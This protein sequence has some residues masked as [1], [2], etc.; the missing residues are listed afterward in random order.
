[1]PTVEYFNH[2]MFFSER[3]QTRLN[4][5]GNITKKAKEVFQCG[6]CHALALALHEEAGLP[7][8]GLYNDSDTDTPSHVVVQVKGNVLL[9]IT[10][11]GPE[12]TPLWRRCEPRPLTKQ[13][14]EQFAELDYLEPNKDV[15][16]PFAKTLLK[17]YGIEPFKP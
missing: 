2:T 15:A 13:E 4:A 3:T 16:R 17:K 14:V 12:N 5:K 6:Q 1:M 7:L 8:V 11:L 9:D 10:G